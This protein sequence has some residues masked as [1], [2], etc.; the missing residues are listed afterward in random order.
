MLENP[1][2]EQYYWSIGQEQQQVYMN[3]DMILL[4]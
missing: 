3:M 4:D 1:D 2:F